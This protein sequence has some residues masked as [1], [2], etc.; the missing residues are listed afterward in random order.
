MD[1]KKYVY[2]ICNPVTEQY[3]I[4]VTKNDPE[5]RL[6]Q[7]QTGNGC[8]LH[9]VATHLTD[10]AYYIEN[11]LHKELSGH[12]VKNEWFEITGVNPLVEFKRICSKY[13][14]II[15]KMRANMF[16]KKMSRTV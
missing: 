14:D 15:V 10:N 7:L 9:I 11:M 5:K 13:E 16:F 12:N 2:L 1:G 3:K 6:K 4:G 8:E